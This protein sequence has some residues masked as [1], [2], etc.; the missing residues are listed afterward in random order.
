MSLVPPQKNRD[1]ARTCRPLFPSR[2]NG[3]TG[4][5]LNAD[6]DTLLRS[7]VSR[8]AGIVRLNRGDAHRFRF[9]LSLMAIEYR[10][11]RQCIESERARGFLRR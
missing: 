11:H 8:T 1:I 10:Q 7:A 4:K 3:R 2:I 6:F 5:E 9:K